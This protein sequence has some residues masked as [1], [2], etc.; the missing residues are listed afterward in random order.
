MPISAG[1]T[2]GD[3]EIIDLL[4]SARTGVT[5]KVRNAIVQRFEALRVLPKAIQDDQ[6]A[7]TR[8]LREAKVHAR[9]N[10]PN[11]VS[12]Y[13][14]TQ[15][16]GNLVMTTEF[17]EGT[18]LA[19]RLE[20]GALPLSEALACF[21]Q[22]LS[23]LGHAHGV[24]VVHRDISSSNIILTPEGK[25]KLS[26]FT[27]AKANSDPQLTQ[28]G[29]VIGSLDYMSP[30]QVKGLTDLDARTDIYSLGAVFYEAIVGRKP[31]EQKSQFE[32]MVAHVNTIP[33]APSVINPD[34]PVEVSEIILKAMAKDPAARF[35]TAEEFRGRVDQ[36]RGV[37]HPF[38]VPAPAPQEPVAEPA[39]ESVEIPAT[40]EMSDPEPGIRWNSW[41]LLAAGLCTFLVVMIV[42]LIFVARRHT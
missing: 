35:Q 18:T 25:V 27:L 37:A 33:T 4:E 13:H 36:L 24:G 22:V 41:N 15:L 39:S 28:P 38:A 19:Q 34:L 6:D 9:M 12:F 21:S 30:E 40:V 31:F 2:L 11:V 16:E 29:T 3:Y 1:Q 14:A 23:G 5:Y 7:V 26:G 17:V 32:I 8:F 10:H 42:M 20:L